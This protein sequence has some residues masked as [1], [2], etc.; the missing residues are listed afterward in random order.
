MPPAPGCRDGLGSAQFLVIDPS[1]PRRSTWWALFAIL[2]VGILAWSIATPLMSGPDEGA[3]ASRAASVAR[4]Q[5]TGPLRKLIIDNWVVQVPEAFAHSGRAN[6][7]FDAPFA[8]T[9]VGPASLTPACVGSF[10][11][12]NRLVDDLTY[13]F[14]GTP[15]IYG[16]LGLPS[17]VFPDGRGMWLMRVINAL[18]CAALLASACMSALHRPGRRLAIVGVLAS[19]T[20]MVWYLAGLVNPN[21]IEIAAAICLW[22]SAIGLAMHDA[23]ESDHRLVTRS[24][25]ALA[26]LV[27]IRALGPAFALAVFVACG[28]LASRAR[29]RELWHRRDVRTWGCVA[30]V[31]TAVTA[32]WVLR[33]GTPNEAPYRTIGFSRAADRLPMMWRQTVGAFAT[34]YLPLPRLVAYGWGAIVIVGLAVAFGRI[35]A[36]Q[37]VILGAAVAAA[38]ALSVGADGFG[39]PNIGFDWQGRYGLPLTAGAVMLAFALPPDRGRPI[40]TFGATAIGFLLVGH[41]A[42]YMAIGRRLGMGVVSGNNILDYVIRPRWEPGLPS[43]VLLAVMTLVVLALG[44]MFIPLLLRAPKPDREPTGPSLRE[45]RLSST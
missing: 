25:I 30:F 12:S 31:S 35:T 1:E 27:G 16:L 33:A 32:L 2:L 34:G 26:I 29:L 39:L 43:G 37:R 19:M 5:L 22:S 14:R 4:G 28:A 40:R 42:A 15:H 24:G 9:H 11:G 10:D 36:R 21:S 3:H 8:P 38:I 20:P 7:F 13:E 45:S 44:A 41:V 17:L 6:C 23:T 18:I